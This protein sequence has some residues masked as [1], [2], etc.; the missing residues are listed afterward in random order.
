MALGSLLVAAT[1]LWFASQNSQLPFAARSSSETAEGPVAAGDST[2]PGGHDVPDG[3]AEPPVDQAQM[4]VLLSRLEAEA[5]AAADREIRFDRICRRLEGL[6]DSVAPATHT[7][8][9]TDQLPADPPVGVDESFAP[10]QGESDLANETQSGDDPSDLTSSESDGARLSDTNAS[11]GDFNDDQVAAD[12]A[13]PLDPVEDSGDMGAA[14]GQPTQIADANGLLMG[15]SPTDLVGQAKLQVVEKTMRPL[16]N[17]NEVT[18]TVRNTGDRAAVITRVTFEPT[19]VLDDIPTELAAQ[20]LP[21][22]SDSHLVVALQ[23]A[24]NLADSSDRQG[25][26]VHLLAEPYTIAAASEVDV[27]VAVENPDHRGFGL[28][29]NLTLDF[30]ESDSLLEAAAIAFVGSGTETESG[31]DPTTDE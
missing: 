26:Y 19:S 15:S 31:S 6:A 20:P 7:S 1:A 24:D 17:E 29:G 27:L 18:M 2:R 4:A 11:Q 3:L 12:A 9:I 8:S 5:Q 28:F 30:N 16:A 22:S 23:P 13:N 21:G 10:K 14:D 25:R